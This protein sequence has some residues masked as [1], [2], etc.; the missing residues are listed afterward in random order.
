MRNLVTHQ[1]QE[2]VLK[3]TLVPLVQRRLLRMYG[4]DT[5]AYETF[6]AHMREHALVISGSFVL[7]ALLELDWPDSDIDV[8]KVVDG[9]A[10][11]PNHGVAKARFQDQ[12]RKIATP[13]FK[14]SRKAGHYQWDEH[15]INAVYTFERSGG[16]GIVPPGAIVDRMQVIEILLRPQSAR[17]PPGA[18]IDAPLVQ[19]D[20]IDEY[21]F[22]TFDLDMCKVI[23]GWDAESEEFRGALGDSTADA[24]IHNR[25]SY[26]RSVRFDTIV[27]RY[28]KYTARGF[29]ID[30]PRKQDEVAAYF[31]RSA[32]LAFDAHCF[33]IVE[34][35]SEGDLET[36]RDQLV[37]CPQDT[38]FATLCDIVHLHARGVNLDGYRHVNIVMLKERLA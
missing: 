9:L 27:Q 8:W 19:F 20:T 13:E 12:A 38:C 30:L 16:V 25:C 14:Q 1:I 24:L 22:A 3:R 29:R 34:L 7:Q 10:P 33:Q 11:I 36:Y 28:R 15:H 23:F 35:E 37:P 31:R 5:N 26:T 17:R 4:Q 18:N 21:I 32:A 6:L 2:Q